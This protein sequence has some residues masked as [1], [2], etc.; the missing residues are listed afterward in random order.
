MEKLPKNLEST[1]LDFTAR[2]QA[3][4]VGIFRKFQRIF[5]FHVNPHKKVSEQKF[6][7]I[8][9]KIATCSKQRRIASQS[10]LQVVCAGPSTLVPDCPESLG[11]ICRVFYQLC[12]WKSTW[13][14]QPIRRRL[15]ACSCLLGVH[16]G[17]RVDELPL[18]TQQL[19][20]SGQI[21]SLVIGQFVARAILQSSFAQVH[22]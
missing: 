12:S 21:L 13:K 9:L 6:T 2:F 18:A 14:F 17:L 3:L 15:C 16:F 7:L 20:Q 11:R 19:L 1:F 22:S 5:A 10:D 8:E 4:R